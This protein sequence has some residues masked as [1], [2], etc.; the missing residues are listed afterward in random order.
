A[1]IAESNYVRRCMIT[2]SLSGSFTGHRTPQVPRSAAATL[3]THISR[4]ISPR[5]NM[6]P[7]SYAGQNPAGFPG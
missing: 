7:L 3:C 4:E 1:L 5:H 6:V 2:V